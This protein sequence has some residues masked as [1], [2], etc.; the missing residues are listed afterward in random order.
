[1][2]RRRRFPGIARPWWPGTGIPPWRSREGEV[3]ETC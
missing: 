2:E 3:T 1:M